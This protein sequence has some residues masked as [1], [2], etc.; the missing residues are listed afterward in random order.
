MVHTRDWKTAY[1]GTDLV[2]IK[3]KTR[4]KVFEEL[5]SEYFCRPITQHPYVLNC[6]N[7]RTSF[8]MRSRKAQ[9]NVL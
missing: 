1:R 7:F 5:T 8:E 2:K 3:T 9:I 6:E 4:F